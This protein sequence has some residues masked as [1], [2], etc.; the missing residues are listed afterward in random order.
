MGRSVSAARRARGIAKIL[1]TVDDAIRLTEL[2]IA[3]LKMMNQ[4]LLHDL[5]ALG[6]E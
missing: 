5:V 1:D 3:K 2:V 4:G 6:I